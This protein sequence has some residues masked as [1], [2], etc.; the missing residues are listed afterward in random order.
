VLLCPNFNLVLND[1]GVLLQPADVFSRGVASR[2]VLWSKPA[3]YMTFFMT[4]PSAPLLCSAALLLSAGCRSSPDRTQQ[5]RPDAS[6]PARDVSPLALLSPRAGDTLVEGD[7]YVIRWSAPAGMRIN[8]GAAMGGK[9]KGMLLVGA[10]A[11]P[12]SLV[13]KV[14]VGF[15]TGFGVASSDQVR[16]RLED[17]D[18]AGHYVET[19]PFTVGGIGRR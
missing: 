4:A 6:S 10:P 11:Q 15:V 16:L 2:K 18:S 7:T 9:D 17:A 19:R 1:T 14:P 12:E 13:W 5:Q 3:R 8:L